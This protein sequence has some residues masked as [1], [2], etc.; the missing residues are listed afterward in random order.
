MGHATMGARGW[1]PS[2]RGPEGSRARRAEG[3]GAHVDAALID[4][5]PPLPP[6]PPDDD[7]AERAPTI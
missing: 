3:A 6:L 7:D 2:A 4:A 1:R 5:L